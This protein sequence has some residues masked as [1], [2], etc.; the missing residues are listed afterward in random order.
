[1]VDDLDVEQLAAPVATPRAVPAPAP[2]TVS[3]APVAVRRD[4]QRGGEPT[5]YRGRKI[6]L[7]FKNADVHNVFRFL[8]EVG[9]V[10]IVVADSVKG[11]VTVRL[12]RVPWDQALYT[13][14]K[15]KQLAVERR[16]NIFS[17]TVR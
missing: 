4:H 5:V 14:A 15:T 10:N 11:S 1:M 7:D 16:G 3:R 12:K 2:Q 8:A 9:G 17:I 6:D 13:I